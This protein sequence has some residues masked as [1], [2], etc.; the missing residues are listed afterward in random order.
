MFVVSLKTKSC[1]PKVFLTEEEYKLFA[2]IL[3][4]FM[5][6]DQVVIYI[7]HQSKPVKIGL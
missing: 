2:T 6:R 3:N 5:V 1:I 7:T 4:V